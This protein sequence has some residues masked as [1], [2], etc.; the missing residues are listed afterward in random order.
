MD[1]DEWWGKAERTGRVGLKKAGRSVNP[2]LWRRLACGLLSAA[3]VA[4]VSWARAPNCL[5]RCPSLCSGCG[6]SQRTRPPQAPPPPRHPAAI[7][8]P[9]PAG[10]TTCAPTAAQT[11]TESKTLSEVLFY[12][13]A[14]GLLYQA[15][16][17]K[18]RVTCCTQANGR[19]DAKRLPG[20]V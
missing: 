17:K 14:A 5:P 8:A 11:E 4:E 2:E 20:L 13:T 19:N 7:G 3:D 10:G 15:F 9:P 6:R 18:W 1:V 12:I 16:N